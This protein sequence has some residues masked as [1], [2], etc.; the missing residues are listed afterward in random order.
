AGVAL[1][2]KRDLPQALDADEL[3]RRG[4]T[5][6]IVEVSAATAFG[7]AELRDALTAA[8]ER[9]A[10]GANSGDGVVISRERHRVALA[11]AGDALAA[12]RESALA[13]MPPEIVAVD[14]ALAADALATI[15]G[16]ISNEDLLDAI[17]RE[18]CIGK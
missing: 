16:V 1:L 18:F 4:L 13:A 5:F 11:Q 17:F 7:L 3:R 2:N 9:L 10:D 8:L 12:A 6:P 14:L 15:T